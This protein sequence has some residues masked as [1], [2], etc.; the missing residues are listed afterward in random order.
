MTI[1]FKDKH[2]SQVTIP[3]IPWNSNVKIGWWRD[4]KELNLYH[5]THIDNLLNIIRNGLKAPTSGPT[6]NWVSLALEKNTAL[7]YASMSGG[8][9]TFRAA[10]SKAVHVPMNERVCLIYTFPISYVLAN[11][12]PHMRGNMD[13]TKNKLLNE[14]EYRNW[15]KSDQEYYMLTEIRLPKIVDT[16][17]LRGYTR[18]A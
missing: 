3:E 17:F 1:S 9:S 14:G 4:N 6:A 10:G 12:N 11:M 7:G 13:W 2:K 8:E 15:K 18:K 5:G 16:K